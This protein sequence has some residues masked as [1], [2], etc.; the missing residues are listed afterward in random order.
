MD[1]FLKPEKFSTDRSATDA[2]KQWRY[3]HR[4]FKNFLHSIDSLNPN[5]LDTLINYLDPTVY[6]YVSECSTYE[7]AIKILENLYDKAKNEVYARHV[8]ASRKQNPGE[9]LDTFFLT[10]QKLAKDCNFQAVTADEHRDSCIRDAFINGIQSAY[11]R[12]RLLEN[13]SLDLNTAYDQARSLA[14]A[15]EQSAVYEN[16]GASLTNCNSTAIE[17][18][19]CPTD[20]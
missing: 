3:W 5:K 18:K 2:S 7:A 11:I 15:Q 4:T 14:L 19:S 8:L 10:L 1:K 9:S 12:Q 6:E 20:S 13:K 16:T 17:N